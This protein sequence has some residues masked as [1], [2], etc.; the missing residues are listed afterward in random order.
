MPLCWFGKNVYQL[1]DSIPFLRQN[2]IFFFVVEFFAQ[3]NMTDDPFESFIEVSLE[4]LLSL[5]FVEFMLLLN[6]TVYAFVRVATALL[7]SANVVASFIV[8]VLVWLTLSENI[9][10]YYTVG[11]LLFWN[12]L[13]VTNILK[14]V[15]SINIPASIVLSL[16]YFSF[17]YYGAFALGQIL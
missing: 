10:S 2:I 7:F 8:P 13:L 6:K 17:A 5:L 15:L 14:Q 9:L 16:F 1:D 4:I 11:I 12:Y 3:A